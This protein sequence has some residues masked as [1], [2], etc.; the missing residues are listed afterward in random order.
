[1]DDSRVLVWRGLTL[2]TVETLER[3][4]TLAEA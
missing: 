1:M 3:C 2:L 4:R